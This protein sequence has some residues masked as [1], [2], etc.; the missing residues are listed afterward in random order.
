MSFLP[1]SARVRRFSRYEASPHI[2]ENYPFR[3]QI[4]LIYII[5]HTF[6]PSIPTLPAHLTPATTTFLQ[7]DPNH[8]H[9]YVP[10]AQTTS[11]YHASP[12]QRRSEPQKIVQIHTVL[13]IFSDTP[14]IHLTIIRSVFADLLSSSPRFQSHMSIHSGHVQPCIS[15]PLCG[16]MHPELS[17]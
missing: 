4:Q 14:H 8:L 12:P 11:I 6:S 10:H 3:V 13:P 9:S 2:P 16:M 15:F 5:L 7:A 1:C 17:G